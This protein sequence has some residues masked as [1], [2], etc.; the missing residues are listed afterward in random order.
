MYHLPC[1]IGTKTTY[2][3][4]RGNKQHPLTEKSRSKII[5]AFLPFPLSPSYKQAFEGS[6]REGGEGEEG[7]GAVFSC[8]IHPILRLATVHSLFY[9]DTLAV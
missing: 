3:R 5:H 1:L 9:T 6:G 2:N 8:F 4:A 7:G